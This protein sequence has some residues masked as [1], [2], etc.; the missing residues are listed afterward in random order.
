VAERWRRRDDVSWRASLDA[1]VVQAPSADD[2]TV[3]GGTAA[4]VWGLLAEPATVD[5]LV[6]ALVEVYGA[7]RAVIARDVGD[8]IERMRTLG[9]VEA[10]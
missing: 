9:V 4:V 6:D 5:E 10:A 2:P 7:D 8:L 1:V 3:L